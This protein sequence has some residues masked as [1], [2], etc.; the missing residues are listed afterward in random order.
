MLGREPSRFGI[1]RADERDAIVR[2]AL[3]R[4]TGD[5]RG[6]RA[7]AIDPGAKITELST[8]DQ[9]KVE[10]ARAL[11]HAKCRVLILDEPTSSLAAD[12]AERLFSLVRKLR[13]DGLT[14]LSRTASAIAA[15]RSTW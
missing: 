13:G 10:I 8:A 7:H 4:V 3:A 5:A 9:Q 15:A 11:A 6:A 1:V 14:I 2:A 12:D